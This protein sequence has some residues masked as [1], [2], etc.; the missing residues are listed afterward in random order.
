MFPL[1]FKENLNGASQPNQTITFQHF[2]V[3][4]NEA[5]FIDFCDLYYILHSP[6]GE[7][8]AVFFREQYR[9]HHCLMPLLMT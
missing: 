5:V 2:R 1:F 7:Q 9:N 4:I 8:L 3:N 6:L